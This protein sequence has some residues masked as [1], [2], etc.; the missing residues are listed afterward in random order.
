MI[1]LTLGT[2]LTEQADTL[3]E[4]MDGLLSLVGG[5]WWSSKIAIAEKMPGRD[6]AEYISGW[7][8]G[9]GSFNDYHLWGTNRGE[10]T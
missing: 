10:A 7:Y 2:H 4:E 8:G 1:G 9:M 3:F 5:N 6:Q